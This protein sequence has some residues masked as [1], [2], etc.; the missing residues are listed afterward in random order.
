MVEEVHEIGAINKK[1][2]LKIKAC[3]ARFRNEIYVDIREY[4]ENET[5]QGPTKK[6]IR[7]HSENWEAF[8]D[9][10]KKLDSEIKKRA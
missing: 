8:Y 3:L 7:F 2:D 6:G 5:Y 1:D 4:L 10:M 9:L